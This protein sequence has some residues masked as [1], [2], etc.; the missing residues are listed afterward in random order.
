MDR[1]VAVGDQATGTDILSTLYA[2]MRDTAVPVDLP[3]LF[4]SLGVIADGDGV[5]FDDSAPLAA[6]R[7][8]IGS[9]AA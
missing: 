7:R 8:A 6:I 3:A 4:A 2:E 5:R 1:L 9:S